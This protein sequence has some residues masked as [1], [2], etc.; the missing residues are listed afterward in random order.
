VFK[1]KFRPDGTI[2]RYKTR[3]VAKGYIQKEG[4]DLFYTYLPVARFTTIQV[5]LS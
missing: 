2:E 3:L 1:K 4:E 5:L